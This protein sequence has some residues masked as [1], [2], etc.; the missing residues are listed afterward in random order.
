MSVNCYSDSL[1]AKC[2][3][4]P[5]VTVPVAVLP[6]EP[7]STLSTTPVDGAAV[8]ELRNSMATAPQQGASLGQTPTSAARAALPAKASF[9]RTF[10]D[11][12][13]IW[14]G[15]VHATWTL[16]WQA[17]LVIG[18]IAGMVLL[19]IGAAGR[20]WRIRR[21]VRQHRTAA[22]A[23]LRAMAEELGVRIGLRRQPAIWLIDGVSQPFVWGVWRGDVY[24][25]SAFEATGSEA[26]RRSV[27][28]HEM[29]H[30]WRADAAVNL[31]QVV[32]QAAMFFHPLV[33]CANRRIRQER[34]K[35]CDE[36][37]IALLGV[38]PREYGEAIVGSLVQ[39]Y[40]QERIVS[41]LAVAGPTRNIEERISTIMRSG[42]RFRTRASRAAMLTTAGLAAIIGPSAIVLSARRRGR[43]RS[44]SRS[45]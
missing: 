6:A 42:R 8:G 4:P 14:A 22:G 1:L 28:T 32:V 37:A 24:L 21:Y 43:P 41:S 18:W 36:A 23:E 30:V 33:W 5:V 44:P 26:H 38:G 20:A 25:P 35:C 10:S 15:F 31:L 2:A 16:T 27:L 13:S 3:V 39:R 34:E 11:N 29:A 19:L 17:W 9:S 7:A 45:I 40:E 12:E